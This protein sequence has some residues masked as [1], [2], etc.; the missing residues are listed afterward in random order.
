[1]A[2]HNPTNTMFE[3]TRD[4]YG[5]LYDAWSQAQTRALKL[6]RVWLDEVEASQKENRRMMDDLLQRSR[7]TQE[8]WLALTQDNLRNLSSFWRWPSQSYFD[9]LNNRLDDLSRRVEPKPSK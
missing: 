9:D 1:M 4:T 3:A 2:T 6:G 5:S 8:A 7:Q